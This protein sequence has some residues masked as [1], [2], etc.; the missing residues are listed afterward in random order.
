MDR[1]RAA[2]IGAGHMGRHHARVYADLPGVELAAIIDPS[3]PAN[4]LASKLRVQWAPSVGA[5][6][7][8]AVDVASVAVPT[9]EHHAVTMDLLDRG[10][11]VLVEKPMAATA[12]EAREMASYAKS[13]GLVLHVGHIER[14]HP[15]MRARYVADDPRVVE[16]H[17]FSVPSPRGSDVGVV[18]DM[19]VHDVDLVLHLIRSPVSEVTAR[20]WGP[21]GGHEDSA[22]VELVFENGARAFL[23]ASRTAD[24]RV[25]KMRVHSIHGPLVEVDFLDGGELALHQEITAFVD[26]V[27]GEVSDRETSGPGGVYTMVVVERILKEMSRESLAA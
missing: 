1:L 7:G 18:L 27:N 10:V 16:A 19:M 25:R 2:V 8:P 23:T 22:H 3:E 20:S 6:R 21:R 17:R 11:H 4:G 14:F 9:A 15:A 26:A 24:Q 13:Q 12:K 5:Y